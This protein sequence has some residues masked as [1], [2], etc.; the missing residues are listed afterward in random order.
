MRRQKPSIETGT[1][2]ELAALKTTREFRAA[3]K[4][5]RLFVLDFLTTGNAQHA[6]AEAYPKATG[7]SRRALQWQ[8]LNSQSVV[9][10]LEIWKWR[11]TDHARD[12]LLEIVL[13]QL[14]ASEPGSTAASTFAVQLERLTIGVKGTNKAH[15]KD[16]DARSTQDPVPPVETAAAPKFWI[17]QRVTERD[18]AGVLHTGVVKALDASGRPSDIE[19]VKS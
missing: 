10:L 3:T 7:Q 9:D 15:F 16:P 2:E 18:S 8:V 4:Q 11:D 13:A 12:H 1:P 19:E 14:A 6:M 17:G 5:Q